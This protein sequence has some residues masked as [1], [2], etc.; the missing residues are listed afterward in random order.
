ML[1]RK[2]LHE[3]WHKKDAF[4]ADVWMRLSNPPTAD[5]LIDSFFV[6]TA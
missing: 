3:N 6:Q 4:A 1:K 2:R 5:R